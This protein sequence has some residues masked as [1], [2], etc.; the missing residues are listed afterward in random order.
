MLN[1]VHLGPNDR[2]LRRA[3][4][5]FN[6]VRYQDRFELALKQIEQ[7][8]TNLILHSC[9]ERTQVPDVRPTGQPI[10]HNLRS[11]PLTPSIP[12]RKLMREIH[13]QFKEY[14]HESSGHKIVVLL[15]MGGQ[16]KSWLALDFGREVATE[17]PSTLVLW[18]DATSKRALTRSLE[19]VADRWN[20]RKRKFTDTDS[21]LKY[22]QVFLSE[23]EWL[24]VFD[25]Y[26]HPDQFPDICTLIPPGTVRS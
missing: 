20:S 16:G 23:R 6:S 10:T 15:G 25:N 14:D 22:V 17:S 1:K 26:D 21:R 12:R 4:K 18:L 2:K 19:D 13:L 24:L 3:F 9:Q 8:K 11:A 7:L 5:A